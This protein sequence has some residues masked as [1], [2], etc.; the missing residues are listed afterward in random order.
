MQTSE[1][2]EF[3]EFQLLFTLIVSYCFSL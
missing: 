3:V 2:Y 1:L